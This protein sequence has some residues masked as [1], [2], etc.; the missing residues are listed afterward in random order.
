ML[1]TKREENPSDHTELLPPMIRIYGLQ[2]D[3]R[4]FG[5]F[6]YEV[7]KLLHSLKSEKVLWDKVTT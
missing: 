5:E 1:K 2:N 4:T 7:E 6:S 3:F